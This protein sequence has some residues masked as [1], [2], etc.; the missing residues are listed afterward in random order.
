M[1]KSHHNIGKTI[2]KDTKQK[3]RVVAN[4]ED[5]EYRNSNIENRLLNQVNSEEKARK[6]TRGPY[7]KSSL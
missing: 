4:R 6:R 7:R 5:I 1:K 2:R 3:E